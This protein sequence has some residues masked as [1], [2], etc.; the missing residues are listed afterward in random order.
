MSLEERPGFLR[1]KGK[2]SLGS[3]FEQALVARRQQAFRFTAETKLEFDP[4]NFQ[5]CAGLVSYYNT[6]KFHYLY[7]SVDEQGR[8]FID[9]RSCEAD[10]S[11]EC[12]FPLAEGRT[13]PDQFDDRFLLPESGP[14]WMRAEVDGPALD[15]YWSTD[16]ENWRHAPATL[17]QSLISDEAGKGEGASF[18]GAFIGMACQDLSG[19]DCPADFDYFEYSEL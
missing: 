16:G 18:T 4:D 17:N 1:L 12:T 5:Q 19:Q 10:R 11:L 13:S 2:E 15:F 6:H 9:I 8:R 3:W 14:V 7:I